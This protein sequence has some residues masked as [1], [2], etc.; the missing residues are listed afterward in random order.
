MGLFGADLSVLN[1][2]GPASGLKTPP[3][4]DLVWFP[5]Y[6][7]Q[8]LVGFVFGWILVLILRGVVIER[9][10]AV[11]FSLVNWFGG[12]CFGL[13]CWLTWWVWVTA[14]YGFGMVAAGVLLVLLAG[15]GLVLFWTL[16]V[17]PH[18]VDIFSVPSWFLK[19][20]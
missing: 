6:V 14:G 2:V 7:S 3:F 17:C 19:A 5:P 12:S 9:E 16:L 18:L 13:P 1:V 8:I 4:S 11:Y 20:L 15:S 10:L